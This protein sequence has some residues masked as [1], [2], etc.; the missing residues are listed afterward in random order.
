MKVL[1][2]SFECWRDDTNGGNVLS[3][4][5]EGQPNMQFAQIY[6]KPGLPQN[7]V[8]KLYYHMSDQTALKGLLRKGPVGRVLRYEEWPAAEHVGGQTK[9]FYDFFR[10]FDWSI[11]HICR[12]LLWWAA[13][14]QSEELKRFILNFAPD[15]VFAPCYGNL[16]M[17]RLDR[18]VHTLCPVPMVS[19]VS[20]DNYS[21]RQLRLSPLFWGHRFLLRASIRKTVRE[22]YRWVYTMTGAQAAE[23]RTDPGAE[24][25]LLCKCGQSFATPHRSDGPVHLIYAGGT[26][27]GRDAILARV[28]KA[29]KKINADGQLCLLD[30]YTSCAVSKKLERILNDGVNSR[31]H[32]A[33]TMEEL[34]KRY[35]NSDIALHVESFQ[36]KNALLTR[37]SFS[38]K[39][40]DCLASGCA[41]LA[42][43]PPINAGWQYLKENDAA[44]CV[45]SKDGI[46]AAVQSLVENEALREKYA[47]KAAC[48]LRENHDEQRIKRKLYKDLSALVEREQQ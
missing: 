23:W 12:E 44:L 33:I 45:D 36:K 39:I 3:N 26:Y 4:L 20:D 1:I 42:I 11:F 16:F 17:Q 43:C 6:C 7:H 29:V 5:F 8:C 21:L 48:L 40:V 13:P 19:Y 10:R 27:I 28:A 37:L 9:R 2:V 30:I 41:V 34:K 24:M 31:L 35:A 22:C 15:V 32:A 38:T 25:R 47:A 14:W 46:E 18:W